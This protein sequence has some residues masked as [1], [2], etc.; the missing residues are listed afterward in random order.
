[1]VPFDPNRNYLA[2]L[3]SENGRV[4]T[5]DLTR[6]MGNNCDKGNN[7]YKIYNFRIKAGIWKRYIVKSIAQQNLL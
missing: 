3:G 2:I 7:S 1:M 5:I 4:V 6:G